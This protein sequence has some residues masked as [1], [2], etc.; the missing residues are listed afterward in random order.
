MDPQSMHPLKMSPMA[1][2]LMAKM[3]ALP[4]VAAPSLDGLVVER[5]A[6]RKLTESDL[7]E[8]L[9][10]RQRMA[11]T[12]R[13]RARGEKLTLGDDVRISAVG[14]SNGHMVPFSVRHDHW[15]PLDTIPELPGFAEVLARGAVGDALI[16]DVVFPPDY[17]ALTLRGKPG[18]FSVEIHAAREV[19]LPNVETVEGL[20]ALGLGNT[21]GDVLLAIR[22]ELEQREADRVQYEAEQRVLD[23]LVR[24][25][26]VKVPK[27]LVEDEIRRRWANAEGRWLV[28]Q[29]LSVESQREALDA[30]L[31]NPATRADCERRLAV[32][33]SL[34]A[35][36]QAQHLTLTPQKVE[37]LLKEQVTPFGLPE[38]SIQEAFEDSSEAEERLTQ[39]AWHLLAVEAVMVHAKFVDP[40]APAPASAST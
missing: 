20:R 12:R 2:V 4:K 3:P 13:D 14:F 27:E 23:E 6:R 40:P 24:R 11:A 33:L 28:D 30:W 19:T 38:S 37:Q 31:K 1:Q 10:D 9:R 15:M 36:V 5:P 18:R 21:L 39:V 26:Q 16:I 22:R 29:Q 8:R 7:V 17:P 25:S 35:V 32:S 34:G